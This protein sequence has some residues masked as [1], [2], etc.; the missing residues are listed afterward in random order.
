MQGQTKG[1]TRDSFRCGLEGAGRASKGLGSRRQLAAGSTAS[2]C[3]NGRNGAPGVKRSRTSARPAMSDTCAGAPRQARGGATRGCRRL[4]RPLLR[5]RRTALRP[6]ARRAQ[7]A[8]SA[9]ASRAS[10]RRAR[11]ARPACRGAAG[12][13]QRRR[14]D[15]R[16]PWARS[17]MGRTRSRRRRRGS[18]TAA[19]SAAP[20]RAAARWAAGSARCRVA[21]QGFL[22]GLPRGGC[23]GICQTEC[24]A[25]RACALPLSA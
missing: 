18:S 22:E 10:D 5:P 15:G 20:A 3:W 1:K 9:R 25:D 24:P 14:R 12:A 16:A 2:S 8:V 19:P 21:A 6:A 7:G 13:L 4:R 11:R 23:G 17:R